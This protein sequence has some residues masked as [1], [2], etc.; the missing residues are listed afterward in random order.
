MGYIRRRFE[1][2]NVAYLLKARTVEPEKELM[3]GNVC[4][5]RYDRVT[6]GS[7]VS[8]AVRAEAI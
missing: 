5:T 4:V 2:N 7:D 6:V 1:D 3:L 8:C